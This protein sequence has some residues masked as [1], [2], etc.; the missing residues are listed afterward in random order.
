MSEFSYQSRKNAA[1]LPGQGQAPRGIA[2][3]AWRLDQRA[4]GGRPDMGGG[5]VAGHHQRRQP[6]SERRARFRV[7]RP[8]PAQRGLADAP[9][10]QR[11]ALAGIPARETHGGHVAPRR[12]GP[13]RPG[14]HRRLPRSI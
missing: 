14:L 12:L 4:G 7:R 9:E 2:L 11:R 5:N 1:D 3:R 8:G 10:E 13:V 6:G